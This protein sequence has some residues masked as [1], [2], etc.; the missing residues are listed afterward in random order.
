M[1]FGA[2]MIE[3]YPHDYASSLFHLAVERLRKETGHD[4]ISSVFT[5]GGFPVTRIQK[6]LP[7]RCL[8]TDPD[9]VVFQFA[10]SDLI[11]PVTKKLPGC[12]SAK[13][14]IP[15]ASSDRATVVDRLRWFGQGIIGDLLRLPSKTVPDIYLETMDQMT[16]AVLEHGAIPVVLSP[17]IFGGQRSDRIARDCT[18]CLQRLLATIPNAHF[19]DA[20]SALDRYPRGLMLLGDGMHLTLKGQA[21]VGECLFASLLTISREQQVRKQSLAQACPPH[22]PVSQSVEPRL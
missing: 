19:V 5:M 21:V 17:F 16:R 8:A 15:S 1:G 14:R 6:Y 2:C 11:V 18:Q 13:P 7:S 10:S 4:I 12:S 9:I 20:Y 3:G 22:E